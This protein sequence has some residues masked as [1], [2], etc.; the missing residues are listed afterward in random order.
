MYGRTPRIEP[1]SNEGNF[2]KA[3]PILPAL[4]S[5]S[6]NPSLSRGPVVN[7]NRR[8]VTGK[9]SRIPKLSPNHKLTVYIASQF[10]Q[11]LPK[12]VEQVHREDLTLSLLEE[13]IEF[14]LG[15]LRA[16]SKISFVVIDFVYS[17]AYSLPWHK[18]AISHIVDRVSA[19]PAGNAIRFGYMWCTPALTRPDSL[20]TPHYPARNLYPIYKSLNSHIER[21]MRASGSR[22]LFGALS[23][24]VGM[25][26]SQKNWISQ[27][28]VGFVPSFRDSLKTCTTLTPPLPGN[29]V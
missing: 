1:S 4:G 8:V 28:W 29:E 16:G 12:H 10:I 24:H 11:G 22:S 2:V 13:L 15:E 25:T 14:E 9:K 20:T 18:A 21:I 26:C 5:F 23:T 27:A 3:A 17:G 6:V 7:N 19:H